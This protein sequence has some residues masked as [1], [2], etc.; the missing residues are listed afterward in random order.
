MLLEGQTRAWVRERRLPESRAGEDW[1]SCGG[2]G[3]MR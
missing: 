1:T 2:Q 3:E